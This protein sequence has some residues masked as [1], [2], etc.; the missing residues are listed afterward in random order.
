T[1]KREVSRLFTDSYAALFNPQTDPLR[2][3]RAVQITARVD[4]ILDDIERESD[5]IRSGIAV[6]GRRV[7]AHLMMKRM[8]QA[9]LTSPESDVP[10]AMSD[11]EARIS[12]MV[13]ALES[14]FP[15]NAYPGNVF[16]NNARVAELVRDADLP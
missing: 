2:L 13:D 3:S 1:A 12:S 5:G 15:A 8:G 10:A 4:A 11:L 6:H 9:F 16:K 14:V 7:I